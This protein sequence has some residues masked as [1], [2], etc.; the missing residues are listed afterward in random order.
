MVHAP[1]NKQ[2]GMSLHNDKPTLYQPAHAFD[3][4]PAQFCLPSLMKDGCPQAVVVAPSRELAMQ[5]VRVAQS[6]LPEE[7]R[8]TVQQ[9]IGGANPARQ[10]LPPP[11]PWEGLSLSLQQQTPPRPHGPHH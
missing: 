6:L 10:V 5:I 9:A 11:S 8:A 7:A 3:L 2:C 4:G 1:G